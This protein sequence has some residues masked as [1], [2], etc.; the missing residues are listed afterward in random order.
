MKRI[1]K[2]C[3]KQRPMF[4]T[5]MVKG[6]SG[7]EVCKECLKKA[8]VSTTRF[9][10]ERI[11]ADEV[12]QKIENG[13]PIKKKAP[14]GCLVSLLIVLAIFLFFFIL[15]LAPVNNTSETTGTTTRVTAP[16]FQSAITIKNA[17]ITESIINTNELNLSVENISEQTVDAFDYKIT[18][19]NTYGEKI[20][21]YLLDDFTA[22]DIQIPPSTSYNNKT[23]LF[24]MD[25]ATSFKVA[26]T[27]Y[28]IKDTNETVNISSDDRV[29][30]EIKK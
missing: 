11:Y 1:C 19:Y 27:R 25:A 16:A 13:T 10:F 21:N 4:T 17:Y 20:S 6:Q 9:G 28:H 24:L 15:I 8:D 29:W 5:E 18:A 7:D 12:K 3:G 22:T 26:I 23:S 2:V 30:V 14:T